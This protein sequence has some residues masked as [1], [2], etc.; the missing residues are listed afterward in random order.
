MTNINKYGLS[1]EQVND[2]RDGGNLIVDT[3][4]GTVQ[5]CGPGG[6]AVEFVDARNVYLS[7]ADLD[8][9]EVAP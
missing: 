9:F 6:F 1:A 3:S 4:D 7:A 8:R 2:L 5:L